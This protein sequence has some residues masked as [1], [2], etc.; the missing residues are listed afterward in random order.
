[1]HAYA[2]PEALVERARAAGVATIVA[3]SV[4]LASSRETVRLARAIP[5]VVAAVGLHPSHLEGLVAPETLAELESLARDP[6]VGFIG[7]IGLDAVEA[8]VGVG[9]QVEAFRAQLDLAGRLGR[10]VNLHLRGAVGEAI[11]LLSEL[12]YSRRP[13][14]VVHYF[15]GGPDLARRYLDLGLYLS[16]GKPVTREENLELR[17]AV[18]EIPLERLL[19]ETD[20]Y[21]LPGRRTE[22]RDIGVVAAAV[23]ALKGLDPV[24]VADVTTANLLRL[25]GKG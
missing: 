8:R 2:D 14:A 25:L 10:P 7:E 23:A 13:A 5:R 18:R 21:P 4:D 6:D 16:I 22:P 11:D 9:V 19:L 20:S 24:E 15:V 1:L 3:V 17:A 12:D